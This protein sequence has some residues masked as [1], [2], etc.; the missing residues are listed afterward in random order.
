[1]I[2][3]AF[4]A[5]AA[6]A[7][8]AGL[9]FAGPA[10]ADGGL[11]YIVNFETPAD[12]AVV[13]AA[14]GVDT[15]LA[16]QNCELRSGDPLYPVYDGQAQVFGTDFEV[17]VL[18]PFNIAWP[19][20]GAYVTGAAAVY[21][22]FFRYDYDLGQNVSFLTVQT[23][24]PNTLGSGRPP[25]EFLGAGFDEPL[26]LTYVRFSSDAPFS[27]DDLVI[28]RTDIG[29]GIPEPSAWAL[30]IL[31]LGFAGGVLRRARGVAAA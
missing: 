30:M 13:G 22:E 24:G 31:G 23:A 4:P 29:P 1:M 9:A 3:R 28:G 26:S 6:A 11:Q 17:I 21:A 7:A 8:L 16:C 27:L 25:N 20:I 12:F 14:A 5:A 18:D 10:A 19:A 15:A 2:F